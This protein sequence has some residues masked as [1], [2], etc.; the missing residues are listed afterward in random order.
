MA[1]APTDGT[2]Y[3]R[4]SA[5]WASVPPPPPPATTLPLM[6]TSAGAIGTGTNYARNDHQH[7]SD[8]TKIGDAPSDGTSYGRISGIWNRVVNLAGDVMTGLL[9]LS[10]APTAPLHAATKAYV[11]AKPAGNIV[12]FNSYAVSQTITIPAGATKAMVELWGGSGGSGGCSSSYQCTSG[13][14][15]A[16][17][18]LRKL[19]TGLTAGNTLVLTLG[20]AGTA[21]AP[22]T[23]NNPTG[24]GNGGASTLASGSQTIGTL[25]SG[26]S[27]GTAG[28]MANQATALYDGTPGAG[29]T[30][31]G[32]DFNLIG[33]PG[34]QGAQGIGF[35]GLTTGNNAPPASLGGAAGHTMYSMGAIGAGP[36]RGASPGAPGNGNVG[37]P[38]GCLIWWYA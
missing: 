20:A 16:A 3:G 15:G 1:D 21:G 12:A 30:A 6:S 24:G 28:F 7:P 14:T 23:N 27:P 38:G 13:P 22:G 32:G 8:A 17:G 5:A 10:G 33:A 34:I 25:T 36:T 31:S 2:L 19:L 9:T 29:G 11:D 35:M 18:F 37:N 4:Q 26:G